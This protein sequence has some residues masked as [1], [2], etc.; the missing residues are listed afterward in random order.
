MYQALAQ[1]TPNR[2]QIALTI[3][4]DVLEEAGYEAA[5]TDGVGAVIGKILRK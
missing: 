5:P 3:V 1:G 4:G 2:K